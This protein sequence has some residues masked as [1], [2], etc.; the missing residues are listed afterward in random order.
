[1]VWVLIMPENKAEKERLEKGVRQALFCL[2]RNEPIPPTNPLLN[3]PLIH[4][5]LAER[6]ISYSYENAQAAIGAILKECVNEYG[7]QEPDGRRQKEFQRNVFEILSNSV[8]GRVQILKRIQAERR[9]SYDRYHST[10][11]QVLVECVE[12]KEKALCDENDGAPPEPLR[13]ARARAQELAD[14]LTAYPREINLLA[15]SE[16]EQ[17]VGVIADHE[18]HSEASKFLELALTRL[19]Q[20]PQNFVVADL[21]SQLA[22]RLAHSLINLD[23][24]GGSDGAMARFRQALS[25]ADELRDPERI[26]HTTHMLGLSHSMI[27]DCESAL[28]YYEAA[29]DGLWRVPNTSA[30]RAWIERDMIG[31]LI[32]KGDLR[33]IPKLFRDSLSIRERLGDIQGQMMTLEIFA[34]ALMAQGEFKKALPPLWSAYAMAREWPLKLFRMMILVTLT[35]LYFNLHDPHAADEFAAAAEQLGQQFQFWHQL[36]QLDRIRAREL[37]RQTPS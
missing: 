22:I 5:W 34:R 26:V 15:I 17:V 21:Q 13:A 7:L 1:M 25:M 24:V 30:R 2:S 31:T 4:Q 23:L 6:H 18:Y 36:K 12:K 29:L 8:S 32:K 20:A 10:A 28:A 35:D 27:G 33:P 16:L 3:S 37:S 11:V 9:R 14:C 19:E